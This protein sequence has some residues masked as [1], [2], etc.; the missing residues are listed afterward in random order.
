[1]KCLI[2][3]IELIKLNQI[4]FLDKSKRAC[5]LQQS[6]V[7]VINPL[8]GEFDKQFSRMYIQWNTLITN[9]SITNFLI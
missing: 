2:F 1:M 5:S 6:H 3:N 4:S 7:R 9:S 8:S